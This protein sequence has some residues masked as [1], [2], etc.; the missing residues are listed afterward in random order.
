MLFSTSFS[1]FWTSKNIGV[2]WMG[3]L[4]KKIPTTHISNIKITTNYKYPR[5]LC[6]TINDSNI[7][8]I[9]QLLSFVKYMWKTISILVSDYLLAFMLLLTITAQIT[10]PITIELHCFKWESKYNPDYK[11]MMLLAI[12]SYGIEIQ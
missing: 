5:Y 10:V 8:I 7:I 3:N 12:I 4:S 6:R 11:T 9:L 1:T 2:P